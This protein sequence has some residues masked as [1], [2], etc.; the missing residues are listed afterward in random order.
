MLK[1]IVRLV[2]GLT[3]LLSS[4]LAAQAT[5][6][7]DPLDPAYRDLQVLVDAGLLER[8]SVAQ[9]PL[10]RLVFARALAHASQTLRRRDSA[11]T[12][13]VIMAS[14]S[15]DSPTP[16]AFYHELI[17][18]LR[19]RLNLP[20]SLEGRSGVVPRFEPLRALAIDVTQTDQPTRAVP[21]NNGIGAI[22]ASLNSLLAFRQG[23]PL[24]DGTSSIIESNHS[25][26]TQR[27][28]LSFTPQL[29]VLRRPGGE[30]R[31]YGRVQELQ[32]R[33][34][35][36]NMAIDIGRQYVVW[37]QGRDVGLLNSNNSPP[38]DA[39]KLSSENA[40]T[41]PWVFRRLGPTRL[42]LYYA[43]LGKDQNFPHA[44][45]VAYQANIAPTSLLDLGVSVYTKSGGH[46]APQATATARLIDLLPFLDASA[47]N[48]II[49]TRG[50]FEVSDHY[51]G[52]DG[53]LILPSLTSSLY[54]EVL[55]NDFDVRRLKSVMWEDAGHV[56]GVDLPSLTPS[57]RLR[58]SLEYHH[59]GI[60]YYE[61]HQFTSGQTVHRI[62]TGDPLGPNAQ[63]A[64]VNADW[65][66]TASRRLSVQFAL[67]RRS[68][69]QY[70]NIP[71]PQFGFRRTTILPKEWQARVLAGWQ[72]LPARRDF[73]A[74][75]QGGYQQSRNFD[76]LD[77]NQ[78][79]GFLGRLSL[80]YRFD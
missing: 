25:L 45:A 23:R 77:G 70:T 32:L 78:T 48:N 29:S 74:L 37:G 41:F 68:N 65:N 56:F 44:Y 34:L 40:F 16:S 50:H 75:V 62:L 54:W 19:E 33:F 71:E 13:G 63:G 8:V 35:A 47:Y 72:L 12:A 38:L 11:A 27:I 24:V 20:D 59:T 3:L 51:A 67:E 52:F 55:L 6:L 14:K 4:R 58:A 53:R 60:R 7:V 10:S 18:S 42:S 79:R 36:R 21:E 64:Y 46:G 66:S 5:R 80:Q 28:A 15:S 1:S 61:H 30:E 69:D 73:G 17:Q 76:F 49:G 2:A 39:V 9:R 26:E 57:G 31:A 43:D 22:D